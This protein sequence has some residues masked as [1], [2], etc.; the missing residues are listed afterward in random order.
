MLPHLPSFSFPYIPYRLHNL[1]PQIGN[2]QFK[3]IPL[4]ATQYK[5]PQFIDFLNCEENKSYL[6]EA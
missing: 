3:V 6:L 5:A 4:T 2:E 1:T